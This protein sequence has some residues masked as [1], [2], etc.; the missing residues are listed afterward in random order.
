MVRTYA[1]LRGDDPTLLGQRQCFDGLNHEVPRE[2]TADE[3]DH[4]VVVQPRDRVVVRRA[5]ED[6]PDLLQE[7]LAVELGGA[8]EGVLPQ[9]DVLAP[10]GC[11][12]TTVQEHVNK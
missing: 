4:L 6:L 8:H 2:V 5:V 1:C 3:A 12:E 11:V 9:Q 10:Q 7:A